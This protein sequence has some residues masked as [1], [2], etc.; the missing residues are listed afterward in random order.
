MYLAAIKTSNMVVELNI[1]QMVGE[2]WGAALVTGQH[3]QVCGPVSSFKKKEE[4]E[5][6][7]RD[8]EIGVRSFLGLN[9]FYIKISK[10]G[11]LKSCV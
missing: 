9:A 11:L 5:R 8:R 1:Q 3:L 10:L 7:N 6:K 4:K 2:R